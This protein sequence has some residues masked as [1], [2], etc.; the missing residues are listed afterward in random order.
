MLLTPTPSYIMIQPFEAAPMYPSFT[1]PAARE[2][3]WSALSRRFT[4]FLPRFAVLWPATH[5]KRL[6]VSSSWLLFRSN[7]VEANPVLLGNVF[8][9]LLQDAVTIDSKKLIIDRF[10]NAV[11]AICIPLL[12]G[13]AVDEF[14][15]QNRR[16]RPWSGTRCEMLEIYSKEWSNFKQLWKARRRPCNN[17]TSILQWYIIILT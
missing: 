1:P 10:F 14:Y 2:P 11:G 13:V 15:S 9:N 4:P 16:D 3:C 12:Q 7:V 8:S 5:T 6:I 17:W